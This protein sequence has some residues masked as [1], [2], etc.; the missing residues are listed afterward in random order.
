[1][2]VSYS[3]PKF[4]GKLNASFFLSTWSLVAGFVSYSYPKFD[5]KLNA[6][7]FYLHGPSFVSSIL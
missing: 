5:G 7:F 3:Y 6:S 1:M 4:D 2:F